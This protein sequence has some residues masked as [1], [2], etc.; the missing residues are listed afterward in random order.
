MQV[1]CLNFLAECYYVTFG[2][3]HSNSICRL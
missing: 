2:Y 1:S 3:C